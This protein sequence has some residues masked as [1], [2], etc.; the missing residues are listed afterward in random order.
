MA[1]Y[2]VASVLV[3]VLA[4]ASLIAFAVGVLG[5]FGVPC[6]IRCPQC[7]HMTLGVRQ[8]AN[9]LQCRHPHL[10]HPI[11]ARHLGHPTGVR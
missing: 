4:V 7:R 3:A 11:A 1:V 10:K 8:S 2:V 9:C 6:L 5:A